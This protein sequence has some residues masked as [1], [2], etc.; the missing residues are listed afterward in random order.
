MSTLMF[1]RG[2]FFSLKKR[3]APGVDGVTWDQYEVSSGIIG[4]AFREMV[5][6]RTYA[7]LESRAKAVSAGEAA[8]R[9]RSA[10]QLCAAPHDLS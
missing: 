4:E 8:P 2:A 7:A 3:A 1:F 9:F 6:D 5:K 10:K